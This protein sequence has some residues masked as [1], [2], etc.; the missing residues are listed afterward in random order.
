MYFDGPPKIQGARDRVLFIASKGEQLKYMLQFL[1]L[2]SKTQQSMRLHI[3]VSLGIKQLLV[4]RGFSSGD[5]LGQQALG[6]LHRSHDQVL[7]CSI[8]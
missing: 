5:K 2:V 1:F 7:C 3:V 8:D 4:I 6:T